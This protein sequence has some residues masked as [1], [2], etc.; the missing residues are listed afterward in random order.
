MNKITKVEEIIHF[1]ELKK[2]Q[3]VLDLL[4]S[5][6]TAYTWYNNGGFKPSCYWVYQGEITNNDVPK[7]EGFDIWLS[8]HCDYSGYAINIYY[9]RQYKDN[10]HI[11]VLFKG[12]YIDTSIRWVHGAK[13]LFQ[14]VLLTLLMLEKYIELPIDEFKGDKSKLNSF[15]EIMEKSKN[16]E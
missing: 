12:A 7:V 4:F 15:F 2:N 3:E 1:L 14:N 9:P 11:N 16:H 5:I 8:F 13:G 6:D 10:E